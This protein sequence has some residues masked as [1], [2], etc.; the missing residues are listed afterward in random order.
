MTRLLG[1]AD[2]IISAANDTGERELGGDPSWPPL[3]F[4][5]KARRFAAG[6]DLRLAS[7]HLSG[8]RIGGRALAAAILSPSPISVLAVPLSTSRFP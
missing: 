1:I 5:K 8:P 7:S 3:L 2:R 6:G 4:F